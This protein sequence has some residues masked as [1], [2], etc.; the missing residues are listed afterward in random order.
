MSKGITFTDADKEL[1]RQIE[2]Y[3]KTNGYSSFVAAVRKLCHDALAL[4]KISK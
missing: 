4:K 1:I 3:Q 2:Q